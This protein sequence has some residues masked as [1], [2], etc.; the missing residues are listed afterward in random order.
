MQTSK[1]AVS[2]R[3]LT[4]AFGWKQEDLLP[5]DVQDWQSEFHYHLD[6]RMAS[7]PLKYVREN[8]VAGQTTSY[9]SSPSSKEKGTWRQECFEELCLNV[10]TFRSLNEGLQNFIQ[11][12]YSNYESDNAN[13]LAMFD[14]FPPILN[15]QLKRFE[16]DISL[17][18]FTKVDDFFEFPEEIDLGSFVKG[19]DTTSQSEPWI[20]RLVSVVV[21]EGTVSGGVYYVYV[22][23]E[24]D[25]NFFRIHD[26]QVTPVTLS[27]VFEA[28][29]GGDGCGNSQGWSRTATV[30]CYC[31]KS[32][33]DEIFVDITDD[34]IPASI[35][36]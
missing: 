15:L 27:E 9:V 8:L 18:S 5:R 25:G 6:V 12:W 22:R 19:D 35:H 20:Y 14:R 26:E 31:R 33:L 1:N 11:P 24:K 32:R 28:G 17:D 13:I 29:Y 16:Y 7:T 21:H 2:T 23:P 10:R 3:E 36:D 30:L 4:D 34:D